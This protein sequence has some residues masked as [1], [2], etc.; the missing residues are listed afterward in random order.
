MTLP[1]ES[2]RSTRMR[3]AARRCPGRA[4]SRRIERPNFTFTT[5]TRALPSRTTPA[6]STTVRC[7][8]GSMVACAVVHPVGP[9]R[10][11]PRLVA[12]DEVRRRRGRHG[13]VAVFVG[14]HHFG[15]VELGEQ[16][17]QIALERALVHLLGARRLEHLLELRRSSG[18]GGRSA[19]EISLPLLGR[20][21]DRSAPT[22]ISSTCR[23]RSASTRSTSCSESD[24]A[25]TMR[26]SSSPAIDFWRTS[27]PA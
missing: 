14:D 15:D 5:P 6:S 22:A 17:G 16:I 3:R 25:L 20:R 8:A 2:T 13:V 23:T 27:S 18:S 1:A 4:P 11:P 12:L 21:D 24:A 26:A 7:V 19:R 10:L 9:R